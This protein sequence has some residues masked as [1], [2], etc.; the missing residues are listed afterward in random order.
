VKPDVGIERGDL[1]CP[2]CWSL[3]LVRIDERWRSVEW[4]WW[5]GC[6]W[7][8]EVHSSPR[9]AGT[10]LQRFATW[11]SLNKWSV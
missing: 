5:C 6:G 2:S 4:V 1:V 11:K 3:C 7:S 9:D 8:S 10:L